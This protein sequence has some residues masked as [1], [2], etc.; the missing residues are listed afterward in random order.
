MR[1]NFGLSSPEE[2]IAYDFLFLHLYSYEPP[3]LFRND[4]YCLQWQD[5]FLP[6]SESIAALVR[7]SFRRAGSGDK[8]E[9]E[10][11]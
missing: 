3:E 6:R 1:E 11:L 9:Y 5:D 8:I 10:Q 4:E 7:Q 2:H